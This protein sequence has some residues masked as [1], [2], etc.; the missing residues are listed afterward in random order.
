MPILLWQGGCIKSAIFPDYVL[1]SCWR[2][3]FLLKTSIFHRIKNKN[4]EFSPQI[5]NIWLNF[6]MQ[7][8]LS[9]AINLLSSYRKFSKLRKFRLTI[10]TLKLNLYKWAWCG[11]AAGKRVYCKAGDSQPRHI[12]YGYLMNKEQFLFFKEP[13][14]HFLT[15]S[16]R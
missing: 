4:M 9:H 8:N 14:E 7:H 11:F 6:C 12:L 5:K 15:L 16:V 10:C 2:G 13:K 1:Q 3:L